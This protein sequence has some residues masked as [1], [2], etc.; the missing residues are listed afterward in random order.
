MDEQ[1]AVEEAVREY[2]QAA[3]DSRA[4]LATGKLET[5]LRLP[6]SLTT[7]TDEAA[8]SETISF[9]ELS[10]REIRGDLALVDLEGLW[11]I[12]GNHPTS[13]RFKGTRHLGGPV[14][15]HRIEGLWKVAD[16]VLN[17]RCRSESIVIDPS[18]IQESDGLALSIRAADL[19][20]DGT[21]F[22]AE[23][24]NARG[25][26]VEWDW[27]ALGSPRR[28]S[29]RFE[30][31]GL[32]AAALPPGG[33]HVLHAFGPPVPLATKE[34][35]VILVEKPR[36]PTFDLVVRLD[37]ARHELQ[38]V[39]RAPDSLP[40]RLR[41]RHSRSALFGILPSVSSFSCWAAG[42]HVAPR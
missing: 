29:W 40:L 38:D 17:G 10:A 28:G 3:E 6:V 42:A 39:Q 36:R 19:Q 15:L 26:T 32:S 1:H 18:G 30:E 11:E 9:S 8:T 20:G 23:V 22:Y 5:F 37:S 35:R 14:L 24:T 41:L 4:D 13:G 21:S 12:T 33:P 7:L 16:Y 27:A 2:F 31:L 34:L 25:S